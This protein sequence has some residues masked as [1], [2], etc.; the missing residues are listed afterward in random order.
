MDA[1]S[2]PH[3]DVHSRARRFAAVVVIGGAPRDVLAVVVRTLLVA[4]PTV[5]VEDESSN[6]GL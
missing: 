2:E 3:V 5:R 4:S 6:V 1:F